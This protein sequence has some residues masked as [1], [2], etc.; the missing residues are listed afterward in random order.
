MAGKHG[1]SD[2]PEK[3]DR[4]LSRNSVPFHRRSPQMDDL[5]QF[6]VDRMMTQ[7]SP[8]HVQ[9]QQPPNPAFCPTG[10]VTTSTAAT[11]PQ[12]GGRSSTPIMSGSG[13]DVPTMDTPSSAPSPLDE[14]STQQPNTNSSS[15]DPTM[16][17]LSPH[18]PSKFGP[19]SST[20]KGTGT[21]G[22]GGGASAA[23]TT[24]TATTGDCSQPLSA[25]GGT[26]IVNNV[27]GGMSG[28]TGVANN[29]SSNSNG[30]VPVT[31]VTGGGGSNN[32][33]TTTTTSLPGATSLTVPGMP[34]SILTNNTNMT[35]ST[36]TSTTTNVNNSNNGTMNGQIDIANSKMEDPALLSSLTVGCKN[37]APGAANLPPPAAP[38]PGGVCESPQQFSW[39]SVTSKTE[40][41][42]HW[43][44]SHQQ[45]HHQVSDR[46][47]QQA[48]CRLFDTNLK[49]PSLPTKGSDSDSEQ[50]M[51]A[52]YDFDS[53]NNW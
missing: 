51:D 15:M 4:R 48:D 9:Q 21:G 41:I 52:L 24:T 47:Q 40:S 37:A 43:V 34:S 32:N 12:G 18:P 10:S 49:R 38:G 20:G 27:S 1:K 39:R 19:D 7:P 5:L 46:Q 17:T 22:G 26:P 31:T 13:G 53:L 36:T 29:G 50:G 35:T 8:Q 23:A 28:G 3:F 44:N 11:T 2:K 14:P 42:S 6:D 33:T 25:P 16:P 45:R 30:S